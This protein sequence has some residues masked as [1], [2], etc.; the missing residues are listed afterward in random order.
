VEIR[1]VSKIPEGNLVLIRVQRVV[2]PVENMVTAT[3]I[4][5]GESG[6]SARAYYLK[7]QTT[8]GH[9]IPA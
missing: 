8:F 5:Q 1:L 3:G 9:P 7:P 2:I 4:K 6:V